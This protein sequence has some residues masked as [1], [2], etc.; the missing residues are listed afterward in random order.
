MAADFLYIPKIYKKDIWQQL[1][2]FK[3]PFL[4]EMG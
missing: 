1:F 4:Y 2:A 3:Y